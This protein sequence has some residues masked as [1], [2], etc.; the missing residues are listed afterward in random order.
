[1]GCTRRIGP[2]TFGRHK[3]QR[4][5]TATMREFHGD[6]SMWGRPVSNPHVICHAE[7][8]CEDCGAVKDEG[9]CI[10]DAQRGDQCPA[11]VALLDELKAKEAAAS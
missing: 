4:R 6:T 2:F 11:R 3:W 10:C 8:V 5:V 7:Y 1:M 9:D